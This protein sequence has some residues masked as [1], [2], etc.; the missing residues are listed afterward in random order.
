[1]TSR[2]QDKPKMFQYPIGTVI[3]SIAFI[4]VMIL[5]WAFGQFRLSCSQIEI[6]HKHSSQRLLKPLSL[7]YAIYVDVLDVC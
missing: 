7:T 5:V 2:S 6:Y 4:I 3:W 1:M